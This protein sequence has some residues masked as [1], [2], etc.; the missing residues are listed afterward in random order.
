MK[1]ISEEKYSWKLGAGSNLWLAFEQMSK[2]DVQNV[3]RKFCDS[4]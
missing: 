4:T 2:Q 3:I 1:S